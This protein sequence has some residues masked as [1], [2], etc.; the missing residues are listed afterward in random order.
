MLGRF[1]DVGSLQDA[2]RM[3]EKYNNFRLMNK[4]NLRVELAVSPEEVRRRK[5]EKQV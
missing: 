4:Y 5:M 2:E 3:I 1:V